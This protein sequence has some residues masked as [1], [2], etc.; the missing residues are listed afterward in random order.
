PI[1][2]FLGRVIARRFQ[3]GLESGHLDEPGKIAPGP[4]RD[5]DVRDVDPQDADVFLLDANPIHILHF[6]PRFESD[7]QVDIL[8]MSNAFDAEHRGHVDDADAAHFHM[9]AG[10][11]RAGAYDLPAIDQRYLG[12]IVGHQAV[13]SFDQSQHTLAFADPALA[14]Q[15][16]SHPEN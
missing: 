12:D 16:H 8:L 6:V 13:A 14:A 11:F 9:V 5:D 10:N 7:D 4:D 15:D 1:I 3:L 2:E